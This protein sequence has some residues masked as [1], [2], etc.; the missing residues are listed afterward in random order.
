MR[1]ILR[2]FI[3]FA[4]VAL[5]LVAS[6]VVLYN[7]PYAG[8]FDWR[9]YSAKGPL[10]PIDTMAAG[11]FADG[12]VEINVCYAQ[13]KYVIRVYGGNPG[14]EIVYSCPKLKV[15]SRLATSG[16]MIDEVKAEDIEDIRIALYRRDDSLL[17]KPVRVYSLSQ[18]T[19]VPHYPTIEEARTSLSR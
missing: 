17:K 5:A 19:G 10:T 3:L 13:G 11:E 12:D 18:M 6:A 9:M 14:W 2:H 8:H 16:A 4:V 1:H 7:A 15:S